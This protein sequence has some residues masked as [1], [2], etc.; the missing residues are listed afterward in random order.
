MVYCSEAILL[1]QEVEAGSLAEIDFWRQREGNLRWIQEQV[2]GPQ[3]Q[4][5]AEVLRQAQSGYLPA[6]SR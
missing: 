6:F 1:W 4:A 5:V 2:E 3:I